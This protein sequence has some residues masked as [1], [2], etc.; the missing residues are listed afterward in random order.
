MQSGAGACPH[1]RAEINWWKICSRCGRRSEVSQWR[2]GQSWVD[3]DYL[4]PSC[5]FPANSPEMKCPTCLEFT[6]S[7]MSSCQ[8]CGR[9]LPLPSEMGF[10]DSARVRRFRESGTSTGSAAR[11]E[12]TRRSFRQIIRELRQIKS[13]NNREI[14]GEEE[15]AANQKAHRERESNSSLDES[16]LLMSKYSDLMTR[17]G[18]TTIDELRV[19][20]GQ[21]LKKASDE[22][23]DN[24]TATTVTFSRQRMTE[25]NKRCSKA[26][27]ELRILVEA[28][29]DPTRGVQVSELELRNSFDLAKKTLKSYSLLS[30]VGVQQ[31]KETISSLAIDVSVKFGYLHL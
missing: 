30:N 17:E 19:R 12:K 22:T 31:Y 13:V 8:R 3:T 11:T 7:L 14:I 27:S 23:L 18:L 20:L 24:D 2:L 15:I 28:A 10:I 6:S 26:I 25:A 4:C 1:C 5:K 21:S 29:I 9:G 16:Q